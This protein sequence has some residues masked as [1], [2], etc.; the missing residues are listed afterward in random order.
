M[1]PELFK[2]WDELQTHRDDI[3]REIAERNEPPAH[4][5][6]ALVEE[7][8]QLEGALEAERRRVMASSR[9]QQLG[10]V[11]GRE[12]RLRSQ[13]A[14]V[15]ARI[16]SAYE[17]RL[18]YARGEA[19]P[20]VL[21]L[22]QELQQ[23]RTWMTDLLPRIHQTYL[24][25]AEY[26]GAHVIE[27]TPPE[28]PAA[29]VV[30]PTVQAAPA[31]PAAEAAPAVQPASAQ[32]PPIPPDVAAQRDR[33]AAHVA[34]KLIA[35]GRPPAEAEMTG[36]IVAAQYA[37]RA[38]R[39]NG[40][41]GTAEEAYRNA[42][43]IKGE[44]VGSKPAKPVS[45]GAPMPDPSDRPA[46]AA[47]LKAQGDN[48]ATAPS[49]EAAPAP[50]EPKPPPEPPFAA[51]R[52][53]VKVETADP[54]RIGGQEPRV[55][56]EFP[57]RS[58]AMSS[59]DGRFVYIDK[60]I[61]QFHPKLVREDGTPLNIWRALQIHEIVEKT[62]KEK[63]YERA[64]KIA[65]L[66][67]KDY[68]GTKLWKKYEE[69]MNGWLE[70][71]ENQPKPEYPK[72]L[73]KDLTRDPDSPEV[74]GRHKD[75]TQVPPPVAKLANIS[76]GGN[77]N[78]WMIEN[79]EAFKQA[80]VE[81]AGATGRGGLGGGSE[82]PIKESPG[83][84]QI[85]AENADRA[86]QVEAAGKTL[87]EALKEEYGKE[88]A[89]TVKQDERL[90]RLST[91]AMI[92]HDKPA[93]EA[94]DVAV[95][96]PEA[97]PLPEGVGFEQ[98]K[99]AETYFPSDYPNVPALM[100]LLRNADA[101]SAIHEFGHIWLEELMTDAAHAMAPQDLKDDAA[102]VLRWLNI[103]AQDLRG[104]TKAGRP[105]AKSTKA[106]ERFANAWEQYVWEGRVPSPE[107]KTAFDHFKQWLTDI[108]HEIKN[109][110]AQKPKGD[111][112]SL[113]DDI[114]RV[115]DRM[116]A[117]PAKPTVIM[118]EGKPAGPTIHNIH[119]EDARETQPPEAAETR[120]RARAEV[121]RYEKEQGQK[122]EAELKKRGDEAGYHV[123]GEGAKPGGETSA[124]SEGR[125]VLGPDG[126]A[127]RPEPA[128][129]A[130]RPEHG[131]IDEGPGATEPKGDAV[132]GSD[133]AA[134]G[135]AA[136]GG[137]QHPLAP[138]PAD[139]I[140]DGDTRLVDY[141]GNV[142]PENLDNNKDVW[143]AIILSSER[144]NAFW[145]VRGSRASKQVLWELAEAL[146]MDAST[147]NDR[148]LEDHLER[149][150][151]GMRDMAPK[152]LAAREMLHGSAKQVAELSKKVRDGGNLPE[153]LVEF[154]KAVARHDMIQ[155]AV[156]GA[157]ASWGRTGSAFH[158]IANGPWEGA[159]I[160]KILKDNTGRTLYQMKA[161]A[162][163][164]APF[165]APAQISQF[166][167]KTG[168]AN[169]WRM[170]LEYWINGLISGPV[171]HGTYA[172]GNAILGLTKVGE[173]GLAAG[174]AALRNRP[175]D[176]RNPGDVVRAIEA[177][178][179]LKGMAH[180]VAPA[181]QAA[182]DAMRHDSTTLLRGEIPGQ[183]SLPLQRTGALANPA[184]IDELATFHTV[185]S[186][187][188]GMMRGGKNAVVAGAQ[189][190][191]AGGKAGEPYLSY[192]PSPVGEIGT[193][194]VHGIPIPLGDIVRLP[195]RMVQALHSFFRPLNY[196]THMNQLAY[197]VAA[198][199]GHVG[200]A[201]NQRVA[202]LVQFP[203]PWMVE[204]ARK[205][206]T[207]LT[208]MGQG[209]EWTQKLSRF[210]N[211]TEIFM[212]RDPANNK[213][214]RGTGLQ[215]LK[216][217]DPFVHISGNIVDQALVQR[218]PLGLLSGET[219]AALT[220][221]YGAAAADMAAAKMLAGTA[222]VTTFGT[223]AAEGYVT[224]SEPHS[225]EE[226][227]LWRQVYQP[228]SVKI[229]DMWY[230]LHR[231][232]P[233][234]MLIGS[235]ADFYD[236]AH[237][238][239][240]G[241]AEKAGV[242][243]VHAVAQNILDEN[244]MRGPSDL[245]K[246]VDNPVRYGR[247]YLRNFLSSW[248]PFS[249]GSAQIARESDPFSRQARS[250]MDSFKAKYPGLSQTL[251]PRYDIWGEELPKREAF[252]IPYFSAIWQKHVNEDPVNLEL[253]NHGIKVALPGK[254]IRN[255]ELTDGQY[256]DWARLAGRLAK[257][258]MDM[259]VRSPAYAQMPRALQHDLLQEHLR[260]SRETA[261]NVMFGKYPQ[262]LQ[263]AETVRDQRRNFEPD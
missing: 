40:L 174:I 49:Q 50:V 256:E 235:V 198:N 212:R 78:S 55:N 32:A 217:I 8:T 35:A 161:I 128:S 91:D 241:E 211:S 125:G 232:G 204:E 99:K 176:P 159:D 64:H 223:L 51:E 136:A 193:V 95:E 123:Y 41:V 65:T 56:Q 226:A 34:Q 251:M 46:L 154:S 201:F 144:N 158:S 165:T 175:I 101:S 205:T 17:G 135:G 75:K 203:Q 7:R 143:D 140:P 243:L 168:R 53:G 134:G 149:M 111:V 26:G 112:L 192:L 230:D 246:A 146:G 24:K 220:G 208:L 115:F 33:I 103:S 29:P 164:M 43:T 21:G 92:D 147:F 179:A 81:K 3:R 73:K 88:F 209:R 197:R 79:A 254:T 22:R 63:G 259:I 98:E 218:T 257:N 42:V 44:A 118:P 237:L 166:V 76:R 224:G 262:I 87:H 186:T 28:V 245:I 47:W 106:H 191:A 77:P 202:S 107:L 222:L 80:R 182:L 255:V 61:Q 188:F 93:L 9:G 68:V 18:A 97:E 37:R 151:G 5:L 183:F 122:V 72:W 19:T 58:G 225:A 11:K 70:H 206:A 89:D 13:I 258:R 14:H 59:A 219:R 170:V 199:E 4:K 71:V 233:M 139:R 121:D 30:E 25:A 141:D 119:V 260:Q 169:G 2:A 194:A 231:L 133:E 110:I 181:M 96:T 132:S 177:W 130:V 236:V 190:V 74:I 108:Y 113:N 215:I 67:E 117:E 152:V 15:Q 229:G 248:V 153:D 104:R 160:N 57:I 213:P 162:A 228:H 155:S 195:T 31:T 90:W 27:P 163:L 238:L 142:R 239:E 1:E 185:M 214:I 116:L 173:S 216:F 52:T 150:L 263:D 200:A 84:R 6:E 167:T 114:R 252:G 148:E 261:R 156:S 249:V 109:F 196:I 102:T 60:V 184:M 207:E 94:Y 242:A 124:G 187:A 20:E 244:F 178:G 126:G 157:T 38:A 39:M 227:A 62:N 12:A 137:E 234:G 82:V 85:I 172:V 253:M 66:A 23:V 250:I 129:G 86:E 210:V 171:T 45:P 189:L 120:D 36:A 83:I 48:I 138:K 100:T 16:D 180:G 69:I 247:P 127:A 54:W 131:N 221:K 240:K 145:S 10:P 105:T